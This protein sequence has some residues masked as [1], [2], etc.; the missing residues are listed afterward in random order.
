[1]ASSNYH[2]SCF[3]FRFRNN[4]MF[5][6]AGIVPDPTSEAPLSRRPV[7]QVFDALPFHPAAA[8]IR[9]LRLRTGD[10]AS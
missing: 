5:S 3:D 1:M 10:C 4:Y 9:A 6:E 7:L 2:G 8:G